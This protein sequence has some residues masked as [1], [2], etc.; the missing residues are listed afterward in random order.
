MSTTTLPTTTITAH[1]G[2]VLLALL[3]ATL[4]VLAFVAGRIT[5]AHTAT[6]TRATTAVAHSAPITFERCPAGQ[7][8]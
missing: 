8:C 3:A 7:P 6:P 5:S 2:R 4:L 1:A